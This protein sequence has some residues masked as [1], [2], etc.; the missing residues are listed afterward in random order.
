MWEEA[1]HSSASL[2]S[3]CGFLLFSHCHV[4]LYCDCMNCSPPGSSVHRISKARILEWLPCL[5]GGVFPTQGLNLNLLHWHVDSL[6]LSH[7]GSPYQARAQQF[8][9]QIMVS[10]DSRAT[11]LFRFHSLEDSVAW[12]DK[13]TCSRSYNQTR[14]KARM[15]KILVSNTL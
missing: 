1:G 3:T 11:E 4:Q 8:V 13:V 10:E 12:R 14:S 15:K 7:L 5:L 9:G 6:P 2:V